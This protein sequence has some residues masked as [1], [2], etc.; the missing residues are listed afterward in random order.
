[1]GKSIISIIVAV[2]NVES[3]INQCIESIVEQSYKKLEIILVDDGST[4][5]SGKICD[6]WEAKD[7]R[8]QVIHKNNGGISEARNAGLDI[9]QGE[10]IGFVDGDDF[11]EADMYRQLYYNKQ[12]KGITVCGF[13]VVKKLRKIPIY[14]ANCSVT[15][16]K[17]ITCYLRDEIRGT[18]GADICI[19]SYAWNKLYHYSLF[20]GVR[21][22]KNKIFEDVYVIIEL[23]YK[24]TQV[25]FIDLCLYNYVK[26]DGSILNTSNKV[27]YDWVLARQ[28]QIKQLQRYKLDTLD[29][30]NMGYML[31][32]N[33]CL[34]VLQEICCLTSIEK[35][36]NTAILN[37]C[38]ERANIL[39][40]N[41]LKITKK[42]RFK[43]V[44][45]KYMPFLYK[46]IW[47]LK[48][49]DIKR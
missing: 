4:D 5:A 3:Y 11:I 25:R 42:D 48:N 43:F 46:T 36:K 27:H 39:I 34:F 47:L 16:E 23:F 10:Y 49:M 9:A 7:S 45:F 41:G 18:R 12:S 17:A 22:P 26:R 35:S 24:S 32:F 6:Q 29:I 44:M 28:E 15:G 8:I 33:A 2:Y 21:Y 19:G 38:M 31:V 40:Q 13:Y 1:M 20:K 30:M 37:I 14:Y